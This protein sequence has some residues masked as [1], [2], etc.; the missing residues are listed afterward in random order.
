[1]PGQAGFNPASIANLIAWHKADTGVTITG[2]G[3]S[4]WA[5]QASTG[6]GYD[7][8]QGTDNKRPTNPT[9]RLSG[10]PSVS[11]DGVNDALAWTGAGLDMTKGINGITTFAVVKFPEGTAA[12]HDIFISSNGTNA[13]AGR[14]TWGTYYTPANFET[15]MRVRRLDASAGQS[16]LGPGY[17][18]NQG[19]FYIASHIMDYANSDLAIWLNGLLSHSNASPM[20]DADGP[21]SNTASLYNGLFAESDGTNPSAAEI[22]ELLVYQRALSGSERIQVESY[23][24]AKYNLARDLY[25]CDG[26]SLTGGIPGGAADQPNIWPNI[27]HNALSPACYFFNDGVSGQTLPQMASDAAGAGGIDSRV[28]PGYYAK[29]TLI[30]WGGTNDIGT[31]SQTAAQTYNNL[32]SYLSGRHATG[33]YGDIA[34]VTSIPRYNTSTSTDYTPT[35]FAYNDLIRAGW[36]NGAGELATTYGVT[37]LIDLQADANFDASAD[38]NNTTNYFNDRVHLTLAGQTV[39]AG[40]IRTALGL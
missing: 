8:T 37:K 7:L 6:S 35:L 10:F 12:Q 33:Q 13:L 5:N 23:L 26:D 9:N 25:I 19:P 2:S 29:K 14:F 40:L 17:R 1:M 31:S 4:T 32:K 34:V 38:S 22:V 30:I 28:F 15:F 21:T 11:A 39:V 3:V 27:L 20:V 18:Y 36:N 24:S 16:T